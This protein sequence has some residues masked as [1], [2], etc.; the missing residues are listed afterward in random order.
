MN[1]KRDEVQQVFRL[2]LE[3]AGGQITNRAAWTNRTIWWA[4]QPTSNR[5]REVYAWMCKVATPDTEPYA[6]GFG[7]DT[8][9]RL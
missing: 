1:A 5:T 2:L 4:G 7:G 8:V 9:W 6:P 3:R